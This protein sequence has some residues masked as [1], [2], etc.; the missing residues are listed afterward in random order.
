MGKPTENYGGKKTS[1]REVQQQIF[2]TTTGNIAKNCST[3]EVNPTKQLLYTSES[4][5]EN[6]ETS[7]QEKV[8]ITIR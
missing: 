1:L 8:F 4:N 6:Q 5:L 3:P 2:G 7:P